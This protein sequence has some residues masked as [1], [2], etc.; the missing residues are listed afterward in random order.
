MEQSSSEFELRIRK[1]FDSF[2]K[3][4][5]RNEM[6]NYEIAKKRRQENEVLFSEMTMTEMEKLIVMDKHMEDIER[7]QVLDYDIEIRDELL[8]E[9]LKNLPDK[10]REV[11]LMSYFLNLP[12]GEIAR[13]MNL[14]RSTVNYHKSSSI[15]I[16]R[17]M[18]EDKKDVREE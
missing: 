2:C 4:V 13:E 17:K 11:I 16:L 14:V 10:K 3:K 1:Q 6:V 12:D 18:M 5:L 15:E 7:F 8:G 9:A